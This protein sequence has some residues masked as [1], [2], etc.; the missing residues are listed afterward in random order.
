MCFQ[1][2]SMQCV[3]PVFLCE[4]TKRVHSYLA[5]NQEKHVRMNVAVSIS[6]IPVAAI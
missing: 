3:V 4:N 6:T 2:E 1:R 5:I